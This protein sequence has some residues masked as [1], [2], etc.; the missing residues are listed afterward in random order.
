[1]EIRMMEFGDESCLIFRLNQVVQSQWIGLGWYGIR[2][3]R[4]V[5]QGPRGKRE[6]TLMERVLVSG[7][8]VVFVCGFLSLFI[9]SCISI[10]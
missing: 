3:M 9:Y 4:E 6:K 2:R 10:Y 5:S 1:M 8:D 7:I